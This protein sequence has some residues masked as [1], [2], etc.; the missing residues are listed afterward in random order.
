MFWAPFLVIAPA[1]QRRLVSDVEICE[2][3]CAFVQKQSHTVQKRFH[4]GDVDELGSHIDL[5]FSEVVDSDLYAPDVGPEKFREQDVR[6]ELV[7]VVVETSVLPSFMVNDEGY[8]FVFEGGGEVDDPAD[9]ATL[10]VEE[11]DC[12]TRAGRR[13]FFFDVDF[14]QVVFLFIRGKALEKFLRVWEEV[15]DSVF[16]VARKRIFPNSKVESAL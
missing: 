15:E 12:V 11:F 13:A 9:V 5:C 14:A 10:V 8:G 3:F 2:V 6:V 1:A 7:S 4:V 16:L